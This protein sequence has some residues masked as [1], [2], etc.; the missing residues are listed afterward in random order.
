MAIHPDDPPYSI[1]GL[2]RIITGEKSY[3]KLIEI[4]DSPSNAFTLCTGSMGASPK[5]IWCK[6]LK[7]MLI[8]HHFHI[9]EM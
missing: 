7:N 3:E 2:P 9:F 4:S 5:M 1:F 6:L 8:V